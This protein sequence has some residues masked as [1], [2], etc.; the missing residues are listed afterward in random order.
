M[1]KGSGIFYYEVAETNAQSIAQDEWNLAESPY[2]LKNQKKLA[3]HVLSIVLDE[4]FSRKF[5]ELVTHPLAGS[6]LTR[7]CGCCRP[8]GTRDRLSS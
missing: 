1:Y 6:W 8:A 2:R 4:K 7:A 5:H 3:A